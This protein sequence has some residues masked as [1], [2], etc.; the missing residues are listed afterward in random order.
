MPTLTEI[1]SSDYFWCAVDNWIPNEEDIIFRFSS[2]AIIVPVSRYYGLDDSIAFD[3]F[4][5]IPKRCYNTPVV[6]NHI[7]LYL[8]YFEK[9]YD[10]DHELL[11]Y[12]YRMKRLI[13]FGITDND[14]NRYPYDLDSF[15]HDIKKYILSD[16]MYDKVWKLVEDNFCLELQYK[17]QSNEGLQY[18]DR[19]GKF[20]ME[21]SFFQNICIPLLMHFIYK[22]R[23]VNSEK[24]TEIIFTVYNWLL[25]QYIDQKAMSR[26]MLQ[27]AD[28]YNKL[29]ETVNTTML[30]DYKN[31]KILWEMSEIRGMAPTINSVD[32]TNTLIVQVIPKYTFDKNIIKYNIISVSNAIK[33]NV[34]G[35]NYGY[36]F[37]SLNS[38]KRDGED[39]TSKFDKFEAHLSKMDEGL[40]LQNDFRAQAIME[41]IRA[42]FGPFDNDEIQFYK[43]E[44]TK[45]GRPIVNKFQ[46]NLINDM[47]YKY[48]GDTVSINSI[49]ADEYIILM[50]TAKRILEKHG[51]ILLP[52]IIS[53]VV[54]KISTRTSLCKKEL[55]KLESSSYYQSILAKY[56]NDEK[57]IKTIL[58][59]IATLLSSDFAIIDYHNKDI[60]GRRLIV[61]SDYIID[62]VLCFINQI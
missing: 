12:Y 35:I 33:Y 38:S 46:Q 45:N 42:K 17:N 47:F 1:F 40:I 28:M 20:F 36:D 26:R 32:A 11:L 53:G 49:N 14:G 60:N 7:C 55:V 50:I 23:I 37:V 19:H 29:Y 27:P 25:D 58:T 2:N 6:K 24:I 8:N 34:T 16:G 41:T 43:K 31:N 30:R 57:Q 13:D 4:I 56:N 9:F 3:S 59:L 18:T 5:I 61:L 54:L 22:N 51:M 39:N 10:T 52:Y 44:L 21:I 15:L 48:F 62:E